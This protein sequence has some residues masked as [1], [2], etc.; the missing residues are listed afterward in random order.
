MA[1]NMKRYTRRMKSV[2]ISDEVYSALEE[3]ARNRGVSPDV[4][5][6]KL[7][8]RGIKKADASWYQTFRKKILAERPELANKTKE[9]IVKEFDMLS[10]KIAAGFHFKTLEEME[11]FMRRGI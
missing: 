11:R 10:D 1:Y 2:T 4:L 8:S 9:E 7:I 5:A 3:D 6:E